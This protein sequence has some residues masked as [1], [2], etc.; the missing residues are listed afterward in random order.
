MRYLFYP[1]CSAESSALEYKTSTLAVLEALG[2]EV[3]ELEDWTCCGAS[4]ASTM[5]DL[6]GVVLPARNLALA[7]QAGDG[8]EMLAVCSACYTNFRRTAA[9]IASQRR[10]L[11]TI[12][13][14]LEVE[15][16]TYHGTVQTRHLM[17][18]LANDFDPAD[19]VAR[20]QRPLT[21]LT[22]APYYGCQTVRP[23]SSFDDD[24]R[25]TSMVGI[26]EALGAAVHRH[27]REASCC[28]TSLLTTKPEVGFQM[29]GAI[30]EA[31]NPADCIVTVCPMCHFNL[32]SYQAQVSQMVG[33]SLR[34]PVLFLPQLMGL[35][36]GLPESVLMFKRHV[37][38]VSPVLAGLS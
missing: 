13:Q 27:N 38:S 18:V 19:I 7:E 28:G 32:D 6:L 25:P 4:V 14:A 15:G 35:A 5:S 36:F 17:D 29:A 21:G 23:Y 24:Q 20:V 34:I 33:Q 2:A 10:L 9:A 31:S 26:L 37:V 30:L 1:G 12:N 22:V 8:R 3:E 11:D 16:L